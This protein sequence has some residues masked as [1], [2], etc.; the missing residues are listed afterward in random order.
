M[1]IVPKKTTGGTIYRIMF[2]LLT[3]DMS[4]SSFSNEKIVFQGLFHTSS[5]F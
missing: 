4:F 5:P 3:K 2:D 1:N